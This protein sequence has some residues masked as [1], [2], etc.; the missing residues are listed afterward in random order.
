MAKVKLGVHMKD[1]V[2]ELLSA[3]PEEQRNRGPHCLFARGK[4][5]QANENHH[6]ACVVD[7]KRADVYLPFQD[8]LDPSRE[9]QRL[10][11]HVKKEDRR[12]KPDQPGVE[13]FSFF[14]CE[15]HFFTFIIAIHIT[16]KG[17][18]FPADG[19]GS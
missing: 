18:G 12:E 11:Y 16:R 15:I 3:H 4:C 9:S 17:A 19:G 13:T 5:S 14:L 7:I 8:F 2:P 6:E 10:F 1:E